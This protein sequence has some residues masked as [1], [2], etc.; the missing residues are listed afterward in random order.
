M[1]SENS[2][3]DESGGRRTV[4]SERRDL[5]KAA[6]TLT[7]TGSLSALAGCSAGDGDGDGGGTETGGGDTETTT[8]GGDTE[9][10]AGDDSSMQETVTISY[11]SSIPTANAEARQWFPKSL[12]NFEQKQDGNVTVTLQPVTPSGLLDQIRSAVAAGNVPDLA[13]GGSLGTTLLEDGVTIDHT[14]YAEESNYPDGTVDLCNIGAKYRD[15]WFASGV[16]STAAYMMGLRPKFFKQVGID[17]PMEQLQTWTDVRRAYDE[18]KSEFPNVQ[19]HEV[20]G[21]WNDLEVYWTEAH[22]SYQDGTDPWL[23]VRDQGSYDDPYVKIGENPRT[24]EMIRNNIDLAQSYSSASAAQRTDEEIPSLMLTDRVASFHY[25]LGGFTRYQQVD[26]DV[27]FGWD[28]DIYEQ[29]M[30]R[31]DPNFGD[32]YGFPG[33]AGKEGSHGGNSSNVGG[34]LVFEG[35]DN[36]DLAWDLE[37][38]VKTDLDNIVPMSTKYY[39]RPPVWKEALSEIREKHLSD[40]PQV[41]QAGIQALDEYP[42]NFYG[43]GSKWDIP[44]VDQIRWR[45]INETLSTAIAGD[46]SKEETPGVIRQKVQKT[47]SEM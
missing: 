12:K 13:E 38:Y 30:P 3:H 28:G 45:D 33:L 42:V 4:D 17:D 15:K 32:E 16:D 11:W 21:K 44:P 2:A 46:H 47:L 37:V 10:T 18:V 41:Y 36:K 6:G 8:S 31:L 5:L 35:S 20:T 25:G 1:S 29:V 7:A 23:D 22:T 40:M 39:P 9:T 34:R 26:E 27:T 14:P 19:A 43:T 24:D